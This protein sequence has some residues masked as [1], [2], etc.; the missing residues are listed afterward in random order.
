MCP[1][2]PRGSTGPFTEWFLMYVQ[3]LDIIRAES[4]QIADSD[5]GDHKI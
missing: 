3:H 2:P 5:V 4:L 1:A